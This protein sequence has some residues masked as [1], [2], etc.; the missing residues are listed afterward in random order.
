MAGLFYVGLALVAIIIFSKTLSLLFGVFN[1]NDLQLV[2]RLLAV[3]DLF[4]AGVGL[5]LTFY[6][7]RHSQF[8]PLVTEVTDETSKV[9]WPTW[10]ETK[11]NTVV[12]VIVTVIIAAILW[13]F[14]QVFGRLTNYLLGGGA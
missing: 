2:D 14:D 13:G 8:G 6:L 10:D 1:V 12:T 9:T 3:S 4:G 11:S 5:G 7:Y